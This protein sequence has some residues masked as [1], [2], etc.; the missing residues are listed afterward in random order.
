MRRYIS[1]KRQLPICITFVIA[2]YFAISFVAAVDGLLLKKILGAILIAISVYFFFISERIHLKP[3]LPV[4]ISMGGLSGLMGGMFAMPG[5]PAVLYFLASEKTKEGYIA[6]IQT[7]FLISNIMM[8]LFRIKAG[9][10]T[11]TVGTAWCVGIL[12][13]CAG[14]FIGN[15]VFK[16]I[17]V[18]ILKKIV[19]AYMAVSGI[20]ILLR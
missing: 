16:R 14:A 3:S 1:F 12:G 2:S 18:K 10:V 19:Y 4:Q 11:Q 8:T 5:P 6:G 7:Y 15:K 9:F 17:P 13:V 20:I